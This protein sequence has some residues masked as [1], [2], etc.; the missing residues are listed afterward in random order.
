[1]VT[2]QSFII[3][4]VILFSL[5]MFIVVTRRNAIAILMGVELILNA[6]CLNFVAFN[7]FCFEKLNGFIFTLFIIVMAA[8]EAAVA[9]AI[10]LSIYKN[11]KNIEAQKIDDLKH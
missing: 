4:S 7:H 3:I 2:L 10:V 5:G 8:L 11:F 6:T 9:L 1:M